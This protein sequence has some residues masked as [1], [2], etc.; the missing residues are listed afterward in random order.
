MFSA[1]SVRIEMLLIGVLFAAILTLLSGCDFMRALRPD[2]PQISQCAVGEAEAIEEAVRSPKQ[3]SS[4]ISLVLTSVAC[5]PTVI[6][7]IER[8]AHPVV[9]SNGLTPSVVPIQSHV[10]SRLAVL[11]WLSGRK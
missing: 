5:I 11:K 8:A 3:E 7:K 10:K 9:A 2:L 6:D 4:W 1:R